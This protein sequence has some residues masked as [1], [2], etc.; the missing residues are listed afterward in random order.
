MLA[1]GKI[2]KRLVASAERDKLVD[3]KDSRKGKSE[4]YHNP[5]EGKKFERSSS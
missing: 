2:Q 4:Q 5:E 1:R 3:K